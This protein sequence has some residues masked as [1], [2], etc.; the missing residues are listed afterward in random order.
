MIFQQ[1]DTA[2]KK[3]TAW[4]PDDEFSQENKT[5]SQQRLKREAWI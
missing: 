1:N 5:R 4:A 3:S 2:A